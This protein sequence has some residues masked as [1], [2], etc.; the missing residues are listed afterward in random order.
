LGGASGALA[1][2]VDFEGA[3]KRQSPTGHT[4]IRS[5]VAWSFPHLQTK[6]VAKDF[7]FNL[8]VLALAYSDMF[9]CLCLLLQI[10]FVAAM[11][12]P[13]VQ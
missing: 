11:Y 1:P 4:L 5:T 7:F 12:P 6:R 10:L 13:L 9:W 2:G 8:V 3:P